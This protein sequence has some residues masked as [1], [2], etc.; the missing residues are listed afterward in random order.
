MA[1]KK[2]CRSA[3]H[4]RVYSVLWH[5]S[6]DGTRLSAGD[7][8]S[9]VRA[10]KLPFISVS[11]VLAETFQYGPGTNIHVPVVRPVTVALIAD[12]IVVERDDTPWKRFR[13]LAMQA[14]IYNRFRGNITGI[15]GACVM[16]ATVRP[17]SQVE[18]SAWVNHAKWVSA[19]DVLIETR[20]PVL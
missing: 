18:L 3:E 13:E 15:A 19:F 1:R 2:G 16:Q 11:S 7:R 17:K 10:K 6:A 9:V 14:Q 12:K 4:R 8:G 5:H 20:E